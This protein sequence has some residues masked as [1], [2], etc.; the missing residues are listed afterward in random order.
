MR[1]F[2][3]SFFERRLTRHPQPSSE[4]SVWAYNTGTKELTPQWVNS[5]GS[6]AP[7]QRPLLLSD[8]F[9]PVGKAPTYLVYD[10][11]GSGY[12]QITGDVA[13]FQSAHPAAY[14]VVR[15]LFSLF[16]FLLAHAD[17]D[18]AI[19]RFH[20]LTL[21]FYLQPGSRVLKLPGASNNTLSPTTLIPH[22]T[23]YHTPRI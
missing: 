7:P 1:P 20:K 22:N 2:C 11:N 8:P 12:I 19:F 18:L 16:L 5:N 9:F 10:P 13:K 4:S 6:K 15:H 3:P 21:E 23:N 14:V 17:L